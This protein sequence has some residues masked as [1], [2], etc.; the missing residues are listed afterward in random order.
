MTDKDEMPNMSLRCE[1]DIYLTEMSLLELLQGKE[2]FEDDG[3]LILHPPTTDELG[4]MRTCG[5]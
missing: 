3:R 2:I 5:K 1:E 4:I